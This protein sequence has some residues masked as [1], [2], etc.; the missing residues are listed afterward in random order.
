L[1]LE[2]DVM[3]EFFARLDATDEL[4]PAL[5]AGLRDEL[6]D[7]KLPKVDKLVEGFARY[8]GKATA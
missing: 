8:S 6:S 1:S 3:G 4:A 5:V 2:E 7:L